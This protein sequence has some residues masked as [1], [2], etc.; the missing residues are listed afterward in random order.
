M[1]RCRI[2]VDDNVGHDED[3]LLVCLGRLELL[4]EPRDLRRPQPAVER[5]PS[6][7]LPVQALKKVVL[8]LLAHGIV[9][10]LQQEVQPRL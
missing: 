7:V 2:R 3:A 10:V 6:P 8:L 1:T 4:T 5:D 9:V